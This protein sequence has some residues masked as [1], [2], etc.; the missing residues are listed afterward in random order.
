MQKFLQYVLAKVIMFPSHF[1]D[2][3]NGVYQNT[4]LISKPLYVSHSIPED[5]EMMQQQE[6]EMHYYH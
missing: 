3:T 6:R 2:Q 5:Q 1:Q 4:R